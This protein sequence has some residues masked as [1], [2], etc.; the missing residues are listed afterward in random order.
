VVKCEDVTYVRATD[1]DSFRT[2]RSVCC[3]E[4]RLSSALWTSASPPLARAEAP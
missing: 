1:P 2:H 4:R 3:R